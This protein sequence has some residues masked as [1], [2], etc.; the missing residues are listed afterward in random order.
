LWAGAAYDGLWWVD[1]VSHAIKRNDYSQSFT[2][3]R[4]ALAST[5]S[6]VPV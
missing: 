2:L 6:Q 5:V 4:N 3:K 1:S